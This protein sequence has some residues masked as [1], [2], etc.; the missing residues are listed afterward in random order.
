MVITYLARAEE[1]RALCRKIG[2]RHVQL[3]GDVGEEELA[4]LRASAPEL[5]ITKS[6]I[7]RGDGG[8]GLG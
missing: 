5:T 3:H 6:L 7:V 2:T 8:S 4:K 1:I